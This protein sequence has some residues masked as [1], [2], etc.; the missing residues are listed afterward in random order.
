MGG[1]E[2]YLYL[3]YLCLIAPLYKILIVRWYTFVRSGCHD[4]FSRLLLL[5]P[6]L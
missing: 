4:R 3:Y 5:D 2:L 1:E 6:M